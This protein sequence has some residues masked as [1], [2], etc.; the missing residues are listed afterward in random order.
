MKNIVNILDFGAVANSTEL[1]TEKIQAAID[2][3]FLQGGGV[4]AGC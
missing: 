3:C 4:S 1:Q 2:H